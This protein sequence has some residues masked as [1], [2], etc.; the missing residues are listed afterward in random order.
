MFKRVAV[1]FALVSAFNQLA[2]AQSPALDTAR[3]EQATGMKGMYNEAENVYK[4]SKPRP[5]LAAG[6]KARHKTSPKRC[7]PPLI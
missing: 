7:A 4:I 6:D 2:E 5:N 3:I 1:S